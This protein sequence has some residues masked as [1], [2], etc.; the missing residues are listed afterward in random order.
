M[1]LLDLIAEVQEKTHIGELEILDKVR[2]AWPAHTHFTPT[3]V[4]LAINSIQRKEKQCQ[5]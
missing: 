5:S 4:A 2:R 3:Q 1:T